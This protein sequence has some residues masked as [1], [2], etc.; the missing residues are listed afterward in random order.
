MFGHYAS[1]G[2][3]TAAPAVQNTLQTLSKSAP[4]QALSHA[5]SGI[6]RVLEPKPEAVSRQAELESG[7]TFAELLNE[8]GV[9]QADATATMN[10]L[11]KVYDLRRLRAGQEI[12]LF[13]SRSAQKET[14]SGAVFQP[15]TT[16][17]ISI[18]RNAEGTF[19]ANA[20]VLP[21]IRHRMAAQA[22]IR[23]SLYEAGSQANIPRGIMASLIRIYSH[24]VDFQRDIHPGDRFEVLY[25]QPMT[26]N[27]APV[28]E[29]AI[30]YAALNVG[31][32]VKPVYRVV[33]NDK[34]VD[35]FDEKGR[36]IRRALLR[37]PVAAARI[38]SGFGMRM[39]PILGYS[40]MHQGIDFGAATGT[41]IFAAGSG[42]VQEAGFK[43]GYGRY[44]RIRH[45]GSLSTAYGH[46]SRFAQ[47]MHRGAQVNQG[48][49]IGY[50]GMSGRATG[51][52]LHY[53]VQVSGRQVNPMSINLPTGRILEGKMLATFKQGLGT[54]KKEFASLL[55]NKNAEPQG[56]I[57]ASGRKLAFP[58]AKKNPSC[59][60]RGGC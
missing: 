33:F 42:V 50:V 17:E 36:S 1:M 39:H 58:A 46:M 15:E 19:A 51:P 55:P 27:G 24:D 38:T 35:Y 56:F 60:L 16:R 4:A 13:F 48:D 28:G 45:N 9:S 20:R 37:T 52:H 26:E 54:I 25:D 32:K 34:T 21:V 44:V 14:F 30:I 5:R 53:E 29:G 23:S 18:A 59:G 6:A 2:D 11:S 47:N 7:Q 49:V 8:S 40:K 3:D 57:Q 12:M 31:G 10:A 41:P 43:S 22:E